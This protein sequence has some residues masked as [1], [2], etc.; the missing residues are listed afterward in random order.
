MIKLAFVFSFARLLLLIP[1]FLLFCIVNINDLRGSLTKKSIKVAK[2]TSKNVTLKEID[3]YK[4]S[5]TV[6]ND[7]IS[8]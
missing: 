7:Q 2:Q 6:R 3:V 4:V 5:F 1:F 8:S